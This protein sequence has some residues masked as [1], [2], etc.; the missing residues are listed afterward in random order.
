M[1]ARGAILEDEA[2]PRQHGKPGDA[3][4]RFIVDGCYRLRRHEGLHFGFAAE[5]DGGAAHRDTACDD[6]RRAQG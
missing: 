1:L 6:S 4:D 3:A 5:A 2:S